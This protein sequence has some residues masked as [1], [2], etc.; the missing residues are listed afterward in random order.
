[1]SA[2]WPGVP[3]TCS[4][5]LERGIFSGC[6]AAQTIK[7]PIYNKTEERVNFKDRKMIMEGICEVEE[8]DINGESYSPVE[9]VEI[10]A[11]LNA[12][13][14][15]IF[16]LGVTWIKIQQKKDAD[17]LS[18]KKV[19]SA[20]YTIVTRTLPKNS[21]D[22]SV[23]QVKQQLKEFFED[24]LFDENDGAPIEVADVNLVTSVDDYLNK[25]VD[26][27]D[28]AE[29]VDL[30]IARIE[31]QIRRKVWNPTTDSSKA[32]LLSLKEVLLEFEYANDICL[33]SS[34]D[35]EHNNHMAYVTFAQ[36]DGYLKAL[37][38]YPNIGIF[39]GVS[40][41]KQEKLDNATVHVSPAPE[42]LEIIYENLAVSGFSRML[43]VISTT[44]ATIIFLGISYIFIYQAR[45][46][47]DSY[48]AIQINID[49]S[50]YSVELGKSGSNTTA[51]P[52]IITYFDVLQDTY[53]S[54]YGLNVTN[55]DW[56]SKNYAKCYCSEVLYG[57]YLEGSADPNLDM[58]SYT[59]TH[60]DSNEEVELC[61]SATTVLSTFF[62]LFS[63]F[64]VVLINMFLV[65][66]LSTMV[67][68][69]R[70]AT[71]TG[72]LLSVCFKLFIA[73]YINTALLTLIIAGDLS[74]VGVGTNL[75]F[76]LNNVQ[77]LSEIEFGVF[78]GVI[79]DYNT[80]WYFSVG[81]SLLFTMCIF[82]IGQLPPQYMNVFMQKMKRL[83]DRRW[84]F[85][86]GF[87]L[88]N[89]QEE[90]DASY[91]GPPMP[92]QEKYS[93]LLTLIF[94]DM[95]YSPTMPLFNLI[96]LGNLIVFY[97]SDMYTLLYFFQ[98][99]A[100][101]NEVLPDSVLNCLLVAALIHIGNGM[102]MFGNKAFYDP[103][104]G[105]SYSAY[106][107]WDSTG[108]NNVTFVS[109]TRTASEDIDWIERGTNNYSTI[110]GVL[111]IGYFIFVF[112]GFLR[113]FFLETLGIRT[114]VRA[115]GNMLER[116][117]PSWNFI[118]VKKI[119]PNGY[120]SYFESLT[121]SVLRQRVLEHTLDENIE[122]KYIDYIT[123]EE[124]DKKEMGKDYSAEKS[125]QKRA[126]K[127]NVAF[128]AKRRESLLKSSLDDTSR[129][130][131]DNLDASHDVSDVMVDNITG[132]HSQK[133][134]IHHAVESTMPN[135]NCPIAYTQRGGRDKG[136]YE[137]EYLQYT[138]VET[139]STVFT[140]MKHDLDL[141]KQLKQH[142]VDN[143]N[144]SDVCILERPK[145][146]PFEYE[147]EEKNIPDTEEY[148]KSITKDS[149]DIPLFVVGEKV[150][151]YKGVDEKSLVIGEITDIDEQ[152]SAENDK[153]D[154]FV[155][156]SHF[157]WSSNSNDAGNPNDTIKNKY[158]TDYRKNINSRTQ[159]SKVT[160][161]FQDG[162]SMT[163]NVAWVW[164]HRSLSN[165]R[166]GKF[167]VDSGIE[168]MN[169]IASGNNHS[170]DESYANTN[171]G[172]SEKRSTFSYHGKIANGSPTGDARTVYEN[173][174]SYKGHFL[175]GLFHGI[176]AYTW[177]SEEE[178]NKCYYRGEFFKGL[179]QGLGTYIYNGNESY[180]YNGEYFCDKAHGY[181][182]KV[183][184]DGSGRIQVGEWNAGVAVVENNK[185]MTFGKGALV[186]NS[187]DCCAC[188]PTY[189][190]DSKDLLKDGCGNIVYECTGC[191]VC[192]SCTC[193]KHNQGKSDN[194]LAQFE[195][196]LSGIA[197]RIENSAAAG[198]D[199]LSLVSSTSS[200]SKAN[201]DALTLE[202]HESYNINTVPEY[203]NKFGLETTH[204]ARAAPTDLIMQV[205]HLP[206]IVDDDVI[207][208]IF[209]ECAPY[210]LKKTIIDESGAE[211]DIYVVP[212][213]SLWLKRNVPRMCGGVGLFNDK[214]GCECLAEPADD[215]SQPKYH[216]CL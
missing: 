9:I 94:V 119:K 40:Q 89:T 81:A 187:D 118:G 32:L 38:K 202:G 60:P 82:S 35:A 201:R 132:R 57:A 99:P 111:L 145:H 151:A 3:T 206:D 105:V 110:L 71:K 62:S 142:Q 196:D 159:D 27:G 164:L 18:H 46:F 150:I 189:D 128:E 20:D 56:G 171:T 92:L 173:G 102:W 211:R 58:T 136:F 133:K 148:N 6:S 17:A 200:Q 33:E 59:F 115:L 15:L 117:C 170:C 181:G 25:C 100:F 51:G 54:A 84:S 30:V 191:C 95:T 74:A 26:R 49:C 131:L 34:A 21:K 1:M 8:I 183:F 43:R 172:T 106:D 149:R 188:L 79:T 215:G 19:T 97:L 120:P 96:T 186:E 42:A 155:E 154:T 127:A 39:T 112:F 69:E 98:K 23:K 88:K 14:T 123:T 53:P 216:C 192:K 130:S 67:D 182:K 41:P 141:D 166:T 78:T 179:K 44:A 134:H 11:Y 4:T 125:R 113:H 22:L 177:F 72:K 28:A 65:R 140:F 114:F 137:G 153:I 160:V 107:V 208:D 52:N 185:N 7:Y 204:M 129:V 156:K 180:V 93:Y 207:K 194:N 144:P 13:A 12:I 83:W 162:K 212:E 165:N 87:T 158:F 77:Y 167:S 5:N 75:S 31:S 163:L 205:S 135:K 122:S 121:S 36:E 138:D 64:V 178:E 29:E 37:R 73:Q 195:E 55:S 109:A 143:C 90:L 68:F 174:D 190:D 66:V 80:D 2:Y 86:H 108:N 91:L 198:L 126:S 197:K 203:Q 199:L 101:I 175:K 168:F 193:G 45:I 214:L 152:I 147:K 146:V 61:S 124:N 139:G 210:K 157:S 63:T 76:S 116:S 103:E 24:I 85:K 213:H 47:S 16:V 176:G 48:Q 184:T 104:V 50:T 161:T 169:L 209:S 10:S 70:H